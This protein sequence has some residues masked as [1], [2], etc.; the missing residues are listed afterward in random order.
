[1]LSNKQSKPLRHGTLKNRSGLSMPTESD[2]WSGLEN[3]CHCEVSYCSG[4]EVRVF[5]TLDSSFDGEDFMLAIAD[6]LKFSKWE[7]RFWIHE[8]N[9][10][11]G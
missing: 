2:L 11:R 5:L 9:L 1:M 4:V 10:R 3:Q 8:I 6:Q 7:Q